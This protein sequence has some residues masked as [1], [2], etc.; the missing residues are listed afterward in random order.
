MTD[1]QFIETLRF[2][3][4]YCKIR[5]C[6][7]CKFYSPSYVVDSCNLQLLPKELKISPRLWN[8]EEIE[9]LLKEYDKSNI[10]NNKLVYKEIDYSTLQN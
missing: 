1:K 10:V 7:Q 9:R 4:E 2:I 3:K 5:R 8:I 6:F